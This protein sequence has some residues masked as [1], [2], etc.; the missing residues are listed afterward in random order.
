MYVRIVNKLRQADAGPFLSVFGIVHKVVLF[1]EGTSNAPI[2]P[3]KARPKKNK[4][5]W[6]TFATGEDAEE[7]GM[8]KYES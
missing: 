8:N 3:L 5:K 1:W 7:N 2:H 4:K 6:I